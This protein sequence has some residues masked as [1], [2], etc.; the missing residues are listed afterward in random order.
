VS[1]GLRDIK[2]K[3]TIVTDKPYIIVL[4]KYKIRQID[5]PNKKFKVA[6]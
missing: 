6:I 5:G 2:A 1:K 3:I 4:P